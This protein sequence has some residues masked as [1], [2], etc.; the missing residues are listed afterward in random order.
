[1][2][3]EGGS[4]RSYNSQPRL[5]AVE[6]AV[7]EFRVDMKRI[8]NLLIEHIRSSRENSEEAREWRKEADATFRKFDV[9]VAEGRSKKAWEMIDAHEEEIDKIKNTQTKW[10]AYVSAFAAFMAIGFP[11]LKDY[12]SNHIKGP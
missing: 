4:E 3:Q 11:I 6:I 2:P 7:A 8:E 5:R 12:V 10:S 9:M 1:M